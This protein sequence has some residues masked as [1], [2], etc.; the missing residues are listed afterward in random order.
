MCIRDRV[1]YLHYPAAMDSLIRATMS[2]SRLHA[3]EA[4]AVSA[5]DAERNRLNSLM[6]N[7]GYYFYR[8]GYS[9]FLADSVSNPGR[10]ELHM[11]P[12][13]GMP[14]EAKRKWYLGRMR[15]ELRRS[16]MEQITDSIV[17]R[18]LSVYYSGKKPPIRLRTLLRDIKLRRRQLYSQT[19]YQESAGVINLS[20]IHISEPTR[21]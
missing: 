7:N 11:Q 2:D 19:N 20:L 16:A 18:N 5:L 1:K 15:V 14:D 17:H 8:P 4:F 12:V 6:R 10:V 21:P 13:G 9:V 3:G